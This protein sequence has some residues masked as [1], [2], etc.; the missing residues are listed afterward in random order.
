MRCRLA[1]ATLAVALA[2]CG[3]TVTEDDLTYRRYAGDEAWTVEGIRP[4]Q[5]LADAKALHGEPARTLPGGGVTTHQW[6]VPDNFQ[7]IVDADGRIREVLGRT[8]KAGRSQLAG[9]GM[10]PDQVKRV[11]GPGDFSK[12]RSPSGYVIQLGPGRVTGESARY[13]NGDARF[14]ISFGEGGLRWVVATR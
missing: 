8:V 10:T 1:L 12:Q 13:A 4:G 14:E 5:S 6:Q 3:R 9:P 2:A 7:V 11:L